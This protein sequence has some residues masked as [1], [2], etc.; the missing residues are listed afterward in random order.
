M[1]P[2]SPGWYSI[3]PSTVWAFTQLQKVRMSKIL[4]G[5][6]PVTLKANFVPIY[7]S[8]ILT[9][10]DWVGFSN[11]KPAWARGAAAHARMQR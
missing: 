2:L 11:S 8:A 1:T 6:L 9:T 3:F 5:L 7:V 10:V 4:T